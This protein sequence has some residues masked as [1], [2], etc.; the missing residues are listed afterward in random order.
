MTR[1][2]GITDST[3]LEMAWMVLSKALCN[4]SKLCLSFASA[5]TPSVISFRY[6]DAD[7]PALESR[8]GAPLILKKRSDRLVEERSDDVPDGMILVPGI[9]EEIGIDR[10][11]LGS[12]EIGE[13][14]A[15]NIL[16]TV[17]RD[18]LPGGVDIGKY[19][20][21]VDGID[22]IGGAFTERPE[23]LFALVIFR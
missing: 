4:L 6:H 2:V 8:F 18:L 10:N 7:Y 5:R 20:L 3:I 14:S 13:V 9:F 22:D 16:N 15:Q 17:A 21:L 1:C 23:P 19:A 11:V 12:E